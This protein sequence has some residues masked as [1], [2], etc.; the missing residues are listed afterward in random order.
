[1]KDHAPM[2]VER[3][4]ALLGRV[5]RVNQQLRKGPMCPGG[6]HQV[7][8]VD[9]PRAASLAQLGVVLQD[10]ESAYQPRLD[11]NL[12][13]ALDQTQR[14]VQEAPVASGHRGVER[15]AASH[16]HRPRVIGCGG[17]SWPPTLEWL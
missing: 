16:R 9:R 4:E 3:V 11:S 2:P 17:A 8:V 6:H 13:G 1:M 15:S 10:R 12:P 14:L 5:A 7:D